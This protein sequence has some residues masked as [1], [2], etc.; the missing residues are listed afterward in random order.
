MKLKSAH[1][2]G[3]SSTKKKKKEKMYIHVMAFHLENK[4]IFLTIK[5]VKQWD[6][7]ASEQWKP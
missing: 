1:Q 2:M 7:Q 5:A 4:E 6:R 3:L